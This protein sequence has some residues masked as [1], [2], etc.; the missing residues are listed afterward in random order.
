MQH[1]RHVLRELL[2]QILVQHVHRQGV[3]E[4]L[5]Q[6]LVLLRRDVHHLI[7]QGAHALAHQNVG[8]SARIGGKQLLQLEAFLSDK[9]VKLLL[10]QPVVPHFRQ[11]ARNHAQVVVQALARGIDVDG[12]LRALI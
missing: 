3:E 8:V 4:L 6:L 12:A 5:T 11:L 10:R 9:R 1:Q 7:L 2:A